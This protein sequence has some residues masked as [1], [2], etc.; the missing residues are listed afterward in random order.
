MRSLGCLSVDVNHNYFLAGTHRSKVLFIKVVLPLLELFCALI[1]HVLEPL[2]VL[3][4][5]DVWVSE[6]WL[7]GNGQGEQREFR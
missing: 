2:K 7:P 4:T 6:T 3:F 1:H 5:A